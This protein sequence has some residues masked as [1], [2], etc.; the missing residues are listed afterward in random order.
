MIRQHI[1]RTL[2]FAAIGLGIGLIVLAMSPK[3][4]EG[5][6]QLV[7][8]TQAQ[9]SGRIYGST[10]QE[11]VATI[12]Q[13]GLAI[14]PQTEVQI[15]RGKGV[16][17]QALAK[18][19]L[20]SGQNNLNDQADTLYDLYDV[21]SSNDA[22]EAL[23]RAR[24]YSPKTAMDLANA[25]ADTYNERRQQTQREAIEGALTYLEGQIVQ[26]RED[27]KQEETKLKEAKEE[28]GLPEVAANVTRD[29]EYQAQLRASIDG[30]KAELASLDRSLGEIASEL[31]SR[32]KT[33]EGDYSEQKNSTLQGLETQ[34]GELLRQKRSAQIQYLDD[35][36]QIKFIN[37]SIT[38]VREQIADY[39]KKGFE[40][41]SK[42]TRPDSIRRMLEAKQADVKISKEAIQ[43][44]IS[45]LEGVYAAH[46][47]KVNQIPASAMKLQGI[48]RE[49]EI[50]EINYKRLM[51]QSEDLKNRTD[52][53]AKA[54]Q[55]VYQA[56]ED[57]NPVLPRPILVYVISILGGAIF[58]L[59]VSFAIEAM[60][61]RIY[62]STQL[63]E[64][65]GLPV[66]GVVHDLPGPTARKLLTSVREPNPLISE[67]YRF[68]AFAAMSGKTEGPRK[69]LMT[70][71]DNKAGCST[72]AAQFATALAQAGSRVLLLDCAL[73]EP[74][75]TKV[76][77][78]EQKSGVS[79]ILSQTQLPTSDSSIG[80][81]T[82]TPNLR[83]VGAGT[84]AKNAIKIATTQNI[85]AMINSLAS[86]CDVLV[87]D[88]L[89]CLSSSDAARL[90]P[91]V[92]E[93]FLIANAKTTNM[94][95][96]AAAIDVLTLA[97]AASIK[98]VFTKGSRGEEAVMR[99]ATLASSRA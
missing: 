22:S 21:A 64:L 56:V 82:A 84:E 86:H 81:D 93:V 25:I 9:N 28:L 57:P 90:V 91:Y 39:K 40:N 48:A 42:N 83:V 44:R 20:S 71:I 70:G 69:I 66:A 55:I 23:I 37:N 53:T 45:N 65:S 46:T 3:V 26:E 14:N 60:R 1:F 5:Q 13:A 85:S 72:T 2:L 30:G 17:R 62:S 38:S 41:Y 99:Q 76:F 59:L 74:T 24:A 16:F 63:Q 80:A 29:V 18:I 73:D 97:S 50:K 51:T 43:Q 58:G 19:A 31:S 49:V 12:L 92:D 27:L 15:L 6:T 79:D 68:L 67:S 95:N 52:A 35:S 87:I 75:I 36:D 54:A 32:P 98:F 34:L 8:G 33:E 88:S 94:R 78:L 61:L 96:V 47:A 7:V 11:D 77:G 89:S 10:L 4:Y